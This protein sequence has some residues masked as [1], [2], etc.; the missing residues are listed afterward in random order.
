MPKAEVRMYGSGPRRDEG[1]QHHVETMEIPAWV[2]QAQKHCGGCHSNFYNGRMN[3]T[4][5]PWCF[6]LQKSYARRKTRPPC[7]VS[8]RH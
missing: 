5:K 8:L 4:G 6:S 7:F 2:R 3:C 1:G